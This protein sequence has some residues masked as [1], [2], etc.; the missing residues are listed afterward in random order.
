MNFAFRYWIPSKF[1]PL[2]IL[3][4]L[5]GLGS[6]LFQC[7][8]L[9][10]NY[11]NTEDRL[12]GMVDRIFF[13]TFR[14]QFF[15]EFGPMDREG[16]MPMFRRNGLR[17]DRRNAR[18][19]RSLMPRIDRE[20]M[21]RRPMSPMGEQMTMQHFH[22]EVFENDLHVALEVEGLG[23]LDRKLD[24]IK[25]NLSTDFFLLPTAASGYSYHTNPMLIDMDEHVFL[26][27]SFNAPL[28]WMLGQLFWPFCA[29]ILLMVITVG[30]LIYML[31]VIIKQ[32]RLSDIKNDFVNNMT[33]ELR[34][35]V[36]TV[37]AALDTLEK[38]QNLR[39][40][41]KVARYLGLGQKA[42]AHLTELIDQVLE[43]AYWQSNGVELHRDDVDMAVLI[44]EI[45]EEKRAMYGD[46]LT[47]QYWQERDV[48]VLS[49]D[50]L[51]MHNVMN[52]ILDNAIKY[53]DGS[54]E[55]I[56]E[57]R[58]ME[59][60]LEIK[61]K[62]NGIGIH[63]RD[64]NLIFQPFYRVSTGNRHQVKGFGIGLYYV[65]QVIEAHGGTVSVESTLGKGATFILK[66]PIH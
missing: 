36:A 7:F 51:H 58:A 1:R 40:N 55:V 50:I 5:A 32:K 59:T 34:T 4:C 38:P 26:Q 54:P 39:D 23:Q 24:T 11:A 57:I 49:M 16:A 6:V 29:S 13:E 63:K 47:I 62:D 33:H 30:C 37:M 9:Y 53:A 19:P 22:K 17:D 14:K 2:L 46:R 18:P 56:I 15:G 31:Y 61:I 20:R 45:V 3:M 52:N 35:P 10:T 43:I 21:P 48:P 42:V 44:K 60:Y 66:L 12:R 27:L 25:S 65:K 41:K 64:L 28:P 8:W